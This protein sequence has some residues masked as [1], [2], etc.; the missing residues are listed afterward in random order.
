M[1]LEK[2]LDSLKNILHS[3]ESVVVAF[4]GGVDSTFLAKIAYDVLGEKAVAVTVESEVHPLWEFKEAKEYA[5]SI[6][7]E[8]YTIKTRALDIPKF[9]ENPPDRC[10]YCKR[11]IL[12]ILRNFADKKGFKYV[13]DG[14]NFSDKGDHRPGMQALAESEARS[15]LL[16]A[17]ITKDDI[18]ELS[19]HF[20]LPTWNKPSYACLASRFPYG[21]EITDKKLK[22]VDKA[23]NV[24]REMG[25]VNLR[26]RHHDQIARIEVAE[27]DMAGVMDNRKQ[28][29]E[30]LKNIGYKYVTLD[31]QGYRT[32]SMNE[33]LKS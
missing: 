26:V 18:R 27:S 1:L 32:G 21:E 8:H 12:K 10:Y 29:V 13:I 30:K 23:E 14:T 22:T 4:S 6:G 9:S 31:L 33:V 3:M 19:K 11:E 28:I 7:T 16:E 20:G 15:P 17:K 24:L 5:D 25:F 2:K